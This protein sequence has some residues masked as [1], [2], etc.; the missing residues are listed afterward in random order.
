[1]PVEGANAE[2]KAEVL[3]GGSVASVFEDSDSEEDVEADDA[4]AETD[5]GED[6]EA[7][8][9][10]ADAQHA[11]IRSSPKPSPVPQ[12]SKAPASDHGEEDTASVTSDQGVLASDVFKLRTGLT[13]LQ[14]YLH[15][16]KQIYQLTLWTE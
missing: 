16:S 12:T 2:D 15:C 13:E 1:M 14:V 7:E 8:N 9:P 10:D 5:D 4:E 6:F 11:E 3:A